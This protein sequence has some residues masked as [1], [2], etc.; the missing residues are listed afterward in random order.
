MFHALLLA[1]EKPRLSHKPQDAVA[2][3]LY[4]SA[5]KPQITPSSDARIRLRS[6]HDDDKL[7]FHIKRLT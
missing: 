6:M 2:C 7:T 5:A 3:M 1:E 4:L